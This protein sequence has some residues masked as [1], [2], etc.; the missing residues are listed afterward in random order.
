MDELIDNIDNI[1]DFEIEI[2]EQMI[3]EKQITK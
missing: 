3:E 1:E 2:Q